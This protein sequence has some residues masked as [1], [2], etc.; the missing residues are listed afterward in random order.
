MLLRL[1]TNRIQDNVHAIHRLLESLL[2]IV[3]NYFSTQTSDIVQVGRG[4]GGYHM[5]IRKLGQLDGITTNIACRSMDE[6][7]LPGGCM[8][9]IEEHLPSRDCHNRS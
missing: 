7:S 1:S 3:H 8:G 9:I 5:K 4:G 6:Y 2:F